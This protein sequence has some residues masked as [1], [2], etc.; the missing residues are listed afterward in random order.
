MQKLKKAQM[1]T[2][3]GGAHHVMG[4]PGFKVGGGPAPLLLRPCE[5]GSEAGQMS[6]VSRTSG[7]S[8]LG[9]RVG[10]IRPVF[11]ALERLIGAVRDHG[12]E[13]NGMKPQSSLGTTSNGTRVPEVGSW[14][15]YQLS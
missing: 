4:P 2:K 3:S 7:R 14:A 8:W 9:G 1:A 6:S 11:F 5:S 15:R 10:A 12:N 13:A